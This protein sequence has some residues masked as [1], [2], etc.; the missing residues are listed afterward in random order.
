LRKLLALGNINASILTSPNLSCSV[1]CKLIA[2]MAAKRNSEY[3]KPNCCCL[4]LEARFCSCFLFFLKLPLFYFSLLKSEHRLYKFKETL[5]FQIANS[6]IKGLFGRFYQLS[7][8]L[9]LIK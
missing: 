6:S 7:L 3:Q 9:L 5:A 2:P 1:F 4:K 8:P